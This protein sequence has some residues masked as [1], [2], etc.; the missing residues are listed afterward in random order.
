MSLLS[1]TQGTPERVW[2]L[3]SAVA[4]CGGALGRADADEWLNPGFTRKELVVQ[5]KPEAV[6]QTVNA[7][8]SLGA[9]LAEGGQLRLAEG[10]PTISEATFRDWV[11]DRLVSLDSA[12]K[13]AVVLETYAWIA[14]NSVAEG[15]LLWVS[16]WPQ[17]EFVD[18]AGGALAAG[19]DDDA[20]PR[21]NTTK[22]PSVRR[23]LEYLGLMTGL[24]LSGRLLHP[25]TAARLGRELRRAGLPSSVRIDARE[26]LQTVRSRM[27]YLDGG[28]MFDQAARRTGAVT[29][30]QQLSPLLTAALHDLHDADLITL[31]VHGDASG[32]TRMA[33]SLVHKIRGFQFVVLNEAEA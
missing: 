5:E 2:S 29:D 30:N 33:P 24:P 26:F 10:C 23:W 25:T 32:V 3:V 6:A 12:E 27:P 19:E 4:N 28:R 15:S 18:A 1:S 11:H 9:L 17:K 21:L 20:G 7:A 8:T 16:D 22:L 13:D 31:G 14:V